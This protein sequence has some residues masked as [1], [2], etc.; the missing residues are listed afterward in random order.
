MSDIKRRVPLAL[1]ALGV[2]TISFGCSTIVSDSSAI[3]GRIAFQSERNGNT[4]IYVMNVDGSEEVR[5]TSD[6]SREVYPDWSPDGSKITF[7]SD[8][9]GDK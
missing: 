9:D 5:L 4:D 6:T 1:F 2:I 8:R 7:V 3:T